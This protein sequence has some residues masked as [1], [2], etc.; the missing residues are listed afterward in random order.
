MVTSAMKLKHAPWKK[1]YDKSRQHIKKQ[2]YFFADKSLSSQSYDFP[3]SHIWMWELDHKESWAPKNWC[4]LNCGVGED[5]RVP[6]TARSNQSI[7]KE[8]N[9]KSWLERQAPRLWLADAK[10]WLVG[11]NPDPGKDWRQ[12]EK[13][14]TEDEIVGWHH[15]LNGDE[16]AQTPG[17]GEGQGKPDTLQ[18]MGLQRVGHNWVTEQQWGWWWLIVG[19]ERCVCVGASVSFATLGLR[20]SGRQEQED[21]T[22]QYLLSITGFRIS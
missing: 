14:K 8:V 6:W 21:D 1:S 7:L 18:S 20:Q 17:D 4:F 10:S 2:R 12:E 11:R 16:F 5:S 19:Q 3:S 22:S 15:W 13:G 9:P